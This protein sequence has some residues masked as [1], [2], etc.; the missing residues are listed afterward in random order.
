MS[1]MQQAIFMVV[2]LALIAGC[3]TTTN[4]IKP[5]RHALEGRGVETGDIV[6]L[7]YRSSAGA[8]SSNRSR[9]VEISAIG[10][11]GIVGA[12]EQGELV[13]ATYDELLQVEHQTTGF[14][15]VPGAEQ[16]GNILK[17]ITTTA[18]KAACVVVGA[19]C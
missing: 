18:L 19:Q 4:R 1:R 9:E 5:S 13:V 2:I 8:N 17:G 10:A 12:D 3:S 14:S 16:G 7:R 6:L 15:S 11:D